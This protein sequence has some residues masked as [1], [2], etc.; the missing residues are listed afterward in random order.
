MEKNIDRTSYRRNV[1]EYVKEESKK[2]NKCFLNMFLNQ[3][4]V[5]LL[6]I[7]IILTANY[8]KF[9]FINKWIKN[10]MTSNYTISQVYTS[11]NPGKLLLIILKYLYKN[12]LIHIHTS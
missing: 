6:I 5:S 1:R 12:C 4:I 3:I 9:D 8:Y 7:I 11:L 10:N 2:E